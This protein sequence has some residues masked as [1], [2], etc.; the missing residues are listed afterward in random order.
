MVAAVQEME[1]AIELALKSVSPAAMQRLAEGY[2]E[3][4]Y[5]NRYAH[6]IP[7]GRNSF[8]ATTSGWPD[9][10]S[11]EDGTGRIHAVEATNG[12]W[13]THLDED[14]RKAN[15]ESRSRASCSLL[16]VRCLRIGT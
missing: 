13:S 6:L 8:N 1:A 9:A 12:Q 14:I 16:A 11:V 15:G 7:Q 3:L 10:M 4:T 2:A 5:P